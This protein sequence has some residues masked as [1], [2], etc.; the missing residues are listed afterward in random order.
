[1]PGFIEHGEEP[2]TFVCT[3]N[4]FLQQLI[5]HLL[6]DDSVHWGKLVNIFE[7]DCRRGY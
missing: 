5:C 3:G 6:K 4:F 1:M 2:S 7:I